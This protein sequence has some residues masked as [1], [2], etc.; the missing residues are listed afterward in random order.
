MAAH[1]LLDTRELTAA[2]F[3]TLQMEAENYLP[4]PAKAYTIRPIVVG[5]GLG[6]DN[7]PILT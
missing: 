4:T 7:Q 3:K 2:Y 5:H 6:E 1:G